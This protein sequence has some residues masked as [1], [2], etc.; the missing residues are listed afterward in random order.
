MVYMP[1]CGDEDLV[2][3]LRGY[4]MRIL[5]SLGFEVSNNFNKKTTKLVCPFFLIKNYIILRN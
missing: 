5:C 2:R 4:F 3:I 1:L